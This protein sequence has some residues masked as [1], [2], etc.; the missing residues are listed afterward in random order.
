MVELCF[1]AG[2][3]VS[4]FHLL[5]NIDEEPKGLKTLASDEVKPVNFDPEDLSRMQGHAIKVITKKL[6]DTTERW[7]NLLQLFGPWVAGEP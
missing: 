7:Y 5:T 4:E 1:K 2:S 6:Q 3:Y